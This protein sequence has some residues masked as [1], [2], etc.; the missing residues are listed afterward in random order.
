MSKLTV[1]DE[2]TKNLVTISGAETMSTAYSLM[3]ANK[4]RHLPVLDRDGAIEGILSDR[5]VQRAMVSEV[6]DG[7][8]F[9]VESVK[10]KENSKVVDYMAW[11]VVTYEHDTEIKTVIQAMLDKKVSAFLVTKNGDVVG[12]VTTDDFMNLLKNLLE[13]SDDEETY[14]IGDALTS[15]MFGR[16]ANMIGQ[17][18]I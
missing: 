4:I 5:D 3:F 6:S 13:K 12:I 8:G 2:M 15:P 10:F 9:K 18:G 16:M 7:F 14:M 11:P 17:I 1:A